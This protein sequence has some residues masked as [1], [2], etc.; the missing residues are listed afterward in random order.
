MKNVQEYPLFH[1]AIAEKIDQLVSELSLAKQPLF[2]YE[3]GIQLI[4]LIQVIIRAEIPHKDLC[5]VI[6]SLKNVSFPIVEHD[7]YS[8]WRVSL[9]GE[10][11]DEW[12]RHCTDALVARLQKV[13]IKQRLPQITYLGSSMCS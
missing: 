1:E 10:D 12:V 2:G 6:E 8:A 7:L 3:I 13:P 11:P 9:D 5:L 4:V